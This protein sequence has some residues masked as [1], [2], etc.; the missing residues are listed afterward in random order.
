MSFAVTLWE[1][2]RLSTEELKAMKKGITWLWQNVKVPAGDARTDFEFV[3]LE[4]CEATHAREQ[5]K[6]PQGLS[7]EL[8]DI[9]PNADDPRGK[10]TPEEYIIG[11]QRM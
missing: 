4:V 2:S 6:S 1:D 11:E 10:F 8:E 5:N 9:A 7:C 3:S